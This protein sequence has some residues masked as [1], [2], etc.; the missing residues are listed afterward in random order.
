MGRKKARVREPLRKRK[1][2]Q[3]VHGG[4][5]TYARVVGGR[6]SVL[7]KSFREKGSKNGKVK[8][9]KGE[10]IQNGL[11]GRPGRKLLSKK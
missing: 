3:L 2:R 10:N 11:G 5:R 7:D 8:M 6:E 9:Q 1:D 4:T